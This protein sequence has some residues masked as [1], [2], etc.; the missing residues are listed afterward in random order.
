[1]GWGSRSSGSSHTVLRVGSIF[2]G[3]VSKTVVACPPLCCD[4]YALCIIN[5]YLSPA[6]IVRYYQSYRF[7][8][9]QEGGG[10][11]MS[12]DAEQIMENGVVV[13]T[14]NPTGDYLLIDCR[15]ELPYGTFPNGSPFFCGRGL[16]RW[17]KKGE[18]E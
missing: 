12:L 11:W 2:R 1:M 8:S 14:R 18:R 6:H 15:F 9:S 10:Q 7:A 17:I 4:G 3:A 16:Y 13:G 5:S